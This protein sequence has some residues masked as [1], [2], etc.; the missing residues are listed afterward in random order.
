MCSTDVIA[1]F[2]PRCLGSAAMVCIVSRDG[3]EQQIVDDA[4]VL[5]G[6]V[7]DLGWQR[8]D[9][10]EVWDGQ[11]LGCPRFHPLPRRGRLMWW[12]APAPGIS[13]P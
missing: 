9:D 2:A 1:I 8:E 10:V 5:I 13:V 12:T 4:L 11:Q 7:G 6:D 3:L